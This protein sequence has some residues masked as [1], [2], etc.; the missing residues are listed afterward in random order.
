M[1]ALSMER[2]IQ[3]GE[4]EVKELFRY[5]NEHAETCTAYQVEQEIFARLMQ[6]GLAAMKSYF[7]VKGTGDVGETLT[8]PDGTTA[9]KAADLRGRDY[10]SVFG[11]FKIPRT[12][13]QRR[14]RVSVMPLDAHA[15]LPERCYSSLLQEWMDH[16]SI[17]ESFLESAGTLSTLLGLQVSASRFD[18]VAQHR[19]S[20]ESDEQFYAD[21]TPPST[22]EEGAIQVLS[23]DG[24]GVPVITRDAAQLTARRGRDDTRPKKKEALVGVSYT[25]DTHTRR[26]EEVADHLGSS[27]KATPAPPQPIEAQTAVPRAQHIRRLASLEQPKRAVVE[28]IVRDATAR[29]PK[30]ARP[31]VVVMDGAL[32]LWALVASVLADVEDVGILDIIHVV[33]Y[34]WT[35]GNALHGVGTKATASWVHER[36]LNL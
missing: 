18:V 19:V 20:Q 16:L 31:W 26:A 30:H 7:A 15:D 2:S 32:G 27:E 25:I 11:K 12:T 34:L 1:K 24:K 33:E 36:L 10:F 17:R 4:L 5:V 22:E 9:T 35:A 13:Y 8:L 23:F 3:D 14:G 6:G 29:D 21:K 28:E